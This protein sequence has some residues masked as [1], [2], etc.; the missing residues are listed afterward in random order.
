[1]FPFYEKDVDRWSMAV[2]AFGCAGSS[3]GQERSSL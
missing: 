1:M 3:P 2:V